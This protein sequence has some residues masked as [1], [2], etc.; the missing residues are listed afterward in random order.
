MDKK[1]ATSIIE[2]TFN[3][4]FNRDAFIGFVGN[5][6]NLQSHDFLLKNI[7]IYDSYKEHINSFELVV[8]YSDGRNDIDILIV[9]LIRD[10]SLDRAR[11]M[12]RNLVAR[13]LNEKQGDA[14][15]VAFYSPNAQDWR[16]SLIK[17]EYNVSQTETSFKF[18]QEINHD[19][20]AKRW[21]FLV[22]KNERSHTAQKQL[23][24]IL[25][26]DQVSPSLD[27]LEQSFNIE[28]VTKEFFEKYTDLFHRMKESLDSLLDN[29]QQL[30]SEFELKEIDTSD[31]AKKT[32][33]QMAFLYFLQKK[34]WFGVSPDKEWGSGVKNFLR[35]VFER[36]EKYGE[37][38]FDDV[39][40]PLFYEALAQDRG[41]ESIYPKLN[42]CRMPFLNG[43]LFEPMNGYS[44][45]TTH[46]RLPDE[47]FSNNNRTKEGD[48]GDGILDIFDRYNF[49]VNESDPI[50]MEVAVDPEMMGKVF[51]NLLEI[52][53][54]KSKG[55][56]Y[57]PREI[58]HYMC[59]ESLINYLET[60]TG[61]AIPNSDIEFFIKKGSQIIQ[62][63]KAVIDQGKESEN[64]QY[65]LP[66]SIRN[67]SLILDDLL[68]NIKVCDP[69][70]GSGAFSLGMLNEIVNARIILGMHLKTNPTPYNLKLHAI[71]NSIYGV[72]IDPGAIEIAKLRFWLSL[73]V[74]ED[75]PTPLPNLDH[76]IMQGNSLISQYE[77]IDLF[78]DD[79][80]DNA[81][82][83][84]TEKQEIKNKI[85][86]IQTEYLSLHRSGELTSIKKTEIEKDIQRLQRRLKFLSQEINDIRKSVSLFDDNQPKKI[87]Q[88]KSKLLQKKIGEYV[89][90][91]SKTSKQNLKNEIDHL[92]WDLIELTIEE[93]GETEKLDEIK[94]LRKRSVKPFF[95]WK[96]EFGEV[97]KEDGGFDVIIANPPYIKEYTDKKAFD[98]LR[99]SPYYQGKMDLWYLFAC[100][101]LDLLNKGGVMSFIATNNWVTNFGASK[102]RNKIINDSKVLNLI[103]FNNFKIF[104]SA[105]I[106]TMI[107]I[108]QKNN[109][110]NNYTFDYRKLS[111]D[112][113][114]NSSVL[115]LLSN[116]SVND[117][118]ILSPV[119]NREN[120]IDKP[121]IFNNPIIE[122]VLNKIQKLENFKISKNEIA[123]GIV[124]PQDFLNKKN[125]KTLNN[126][127]SI[128]NG[129]FALN[130]DELQRLS[131]SDKEKTLIKPYFTT[132][133]LFKYHGLK[134]NKYWIIYT[135]SEFKNPEKIE[136]YPNIKNHLDKFVKVIT[137][138][139]KPYGLHRTRSEK[140][141]QG[142]KIISLRKCSDHPRFT[143]TDFDC[144]VSATFYVIKTERVNQKFLTGFL[145]SSLCAFW[146]KHK[147]KMQGNNYQVDKEPLINI[148]IPV[149]PQKLQDSII[150]LVNQVLNIKKTNPLTD[151][152]SLQEDLDLLFYNLYELSEDD[153]S[154]I[155]E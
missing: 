152:S 62:N 142:E 44:W 48:I 116:S 130:N 151:I 137:S 101:S 71:S 92:K 4:A 42:N 20:S 93:R 74:E 100:I 124:F 16:F 56:F 148:P 86:K 67:Q 97:F 11:T 26:N 60:K 41:N 76:K 107:T 6:L 27:L 141:F 111:N 52:K 8:K 147:G 113:V 115:D 79:F 21:S 49:T 110:M 140:F 25:A 112:A 28:I 36:R 73:V 145:N 144:Y 18:K 7:D 103:D 1:Q 63:D 9:T 129:I 31:F 146:L 37:N 104:D 38:F 99:D 57:T 109:D 2:N 81:E 43:G 96:L 136:G 102:M 139:N 5:L 94:N 155:N 22:G 77:G 89:T 15:I 17:M 143:Y 108:V 69:A 66:K 82:S 32:L 98:N 14:A 134:D 64:L 50:E 19:L 70:V 87:A 72:D 118:E 132:S 61:N 131:L 106:Q 85:N 83:V 123:Q 75:N 127:F 68:I 46:I 34:G 78:D 23:V 45:E 84:N 121:L 54:R 149:V 114:D 12:Q 29:D 90:V 59:Q 58:V 128:G 119:I 91:A 65:I 133:E 122:R 117:N 24:D 154:I 138:D 126:A 95:I 10:T 150:E 88:Q 13:Y 3:S 120:F 51:E 80:L 47:L 33:G 153:I 55:A 40:E 53:D 125:N 35:E 39:L 135:S 30:K 105:G